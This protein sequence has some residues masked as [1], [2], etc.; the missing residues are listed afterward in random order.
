MQQEMKA[1]MVDCVE[2][3]QKLAEKLPPGSIVLLP[4]EKIKY[5]SAD[6]EFP[7]RQDSDFYYLS[8]F[9][10]PDAF[11]ALLKDMNNQTEYVLFCRANNKEEEIWTGPRVGVSGAI[12]QYGCNEAYNIEEL[13]TIMPTL[14]EG[15]T[16]CVYTLGLDRKWDDRIFSWINKA[17]SK[18]RKG[19]SYPTIWLDLASHL[20]E[21]RLIKSAF[22]I[23]M[24]R[25]AAHISV[26]GHLRLMQNLGKDKMEYQLEADFIH[27]CY[28]LGGRAMAYP[29]IVGSGKN[30]CILHYTQNDKPIQS[31]EIILVDAGCE[32][33]NYASDIT[34]SYPSSG[35]FSKEQKAIYELVLK[36]QLAAIQIIKPGLTW[37]KLQT[38]IVEILTTGLIELG[39]LKGDKKDLISK[40][41]YSDFY[42][43]SSGHWLGLDVHDVGNYKVNDAYRP[44]EPGMVLTVEPGLYISG[45]NPNVDQKWWDIGVRIEDDVLVTESGYEVLTA[46][47]PKTVAD[48]EKILNSSSTEKA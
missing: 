23:A 24:M 3:R 5:R 17:R 44:L 38:I 40:K 22:E 43:H 1:L 47:L 25:K 37:D 21:L 6:S 16:H 35:L 18:V 13:D 39:L 48:L 9:N 27:E 30:A 34:R 10:E 31:G 2:R 7:F 46:D 26:K 4:G 20:H 28:Q 41:A 11:L 19:S 36:S 32:Y 14:M 45:D 33:M 12:A 42:M 15:K 8:G 29:P